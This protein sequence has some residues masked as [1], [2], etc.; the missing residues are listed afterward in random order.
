MIKHENHC[1]DCA[2]PGYP[3]MGK[4]CPY[5]NVQVYYCDQCDEDIHTVVYEFE[6][7]HYCESCV[8]ELLREAFESLTTQEQAEALNLLLKSLEV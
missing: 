4:S 5:I 3:C 7:G 1:C 8:K 2:V 6:D